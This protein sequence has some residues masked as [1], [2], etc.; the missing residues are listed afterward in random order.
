MSLVLSLPPRLLRWWL[1]LWPPL[2]GAGV[3]VRRISPDF[4]EVV[5]EMPLR[6]YNR[7]VYGAHF[8]GSLYAMTDPFFALMLIHNLGPDYIV[9]DR[10]ASIDYVSPGRSRVRAVFRLEER[11]LQTVR[12]MTE[13][14]AKHLH[15]FHAEVVD[16][17]Q[18]VVARVQK[19]VYVRRRQPG[20]LRG[21]GAMTHA[22]P[23]AG[24]SPGAN[25]GSRAMTQSGAKA[26]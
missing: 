26:R 21:S 23:L 1:N 9:W 17:E 2:L 16:H 4:R 8:G 20:A 10:S 18:L 14:G 7:N 3:C 6:R 12:R 11:D 24:R 15:L 13:A 25:G 5:V 19:L 22:G